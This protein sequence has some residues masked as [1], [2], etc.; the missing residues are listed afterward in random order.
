[1]PTPNQI[2]ACATA[3]RQG[4]YQPEIRMYDTEKC[5]RHNTLFHKSFYVKGRTRDRK[6]ALATAREFINEMSRVCATDA[7]KRGYLERQC[8]KARC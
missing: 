4:I 6:S 3:S 1:M 2:T 5:D 7:Q 8:M